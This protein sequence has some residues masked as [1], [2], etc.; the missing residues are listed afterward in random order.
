MATTNFQY[1]LGERI[2]TVKAEDSDAAFRLVLDKLYG[3]SYG[4]HPEGQH[5]NE[6]DTQGRIWYRGYATRWS[7]RAN[8]HF[9][10]SPLLRIKIRPAT[11][12][13]LVR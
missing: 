11:H 10:E 13:D 9:I 12:S 4:W 1:Q 2:G 6:P 8:A 5:D 7:S 3:R